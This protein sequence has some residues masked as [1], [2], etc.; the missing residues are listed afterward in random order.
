MPKI[1]FSLGQPLLFVSLEYIGFLVRF[2]RSL[3]T[4]EFICHNKKILVAIRTISLVA[5][6][7]NYPI[8]VTGSLIFSKV[9]VISGAGR[10][11]AVIKTTI[12]RKTVC[13]REVVQIF[14]TIIVALAIYIIIRI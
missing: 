1:E 9:G 10:T 11:R 13:S 8:I 6:F 7:P 2:S 4:H 5:P 12:N 14:I 3:N